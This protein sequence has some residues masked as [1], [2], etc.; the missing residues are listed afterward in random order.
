M[1]K[2]CAER[3]KD[4]GSVYGEEMKKILIFRPDGIGDFVVFSAVLDEY[5]RLFPDATID[6]LCPPRVK[7]MVEAIPLF[8][9]IYYVTEERLFRRKY[10]LNRVGAFFQ[11]RSLK[12]DLLIYPVFSR[13]RS[14]DILASW[15]SA[16]EKVAFDGDHANDVEGGRYSRNKYFTKII[17]AR[18]T[19][20]LEIVR[21]MDFI[22]AL[23]GS[24]RPEVLEPK[25][26]FKAQDQLDYARVL[27]NKGLEAGKYICIFPGAGFA[28]RHWD[29]VKW[30]EVIVGL[31]EAYP[32]V[33]IV[34]LGGGKEKQVNGDI[35]GRLNDLSRIVDLTGALN[36]RVLAKVMGSSSLVVSMETSAIHIA[37]AVKVPNICLIGGGHF[38]R[39]YPYGDLAKN[40]IIFNKMDCFGCGWGCIY[41]ESLCIKG[42]SVEAVLREAMDVK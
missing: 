17:V 10:L 1:E 22:N 7:V 12:Y 19:P 18:K 27:Q 6:L 42:I 8:N 41:E 4:F 34:V 15:I 24:L 31:L 39:F 36:L 30:K 32:Q 21:N 2:G 14:W 5:R 25:F 13:T 35:L 28:I 23:G 11:M 40:R 29:P 33:K 3:G 26:W 16:K 20:V 38:E 9:K 37:A